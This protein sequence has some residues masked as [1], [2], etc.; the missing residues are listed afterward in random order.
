MRLFRV[1]LALVVLAVLASPARAQSDP[2]LL[3]DYADAYRRIDS[4]AGAML[5]ARLPELPTDQ[6]A[7][8]AKAP[9]MRKKLS[10]KISAPASLT[11]AEFEAFARARLDAT[12]GTLVSRTLAGKPTRYGIPPMTRSGSDALT[13]YANSGIGVPTFTRHTVNAAGVRTIFFELIYG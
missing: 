4:D 12:I 2:R 6:A 1:C 10:V 11:A 5:R 7:T 8:T 3:G 13:S 9:G